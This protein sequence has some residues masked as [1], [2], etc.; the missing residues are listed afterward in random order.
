MDLHEARRLAGLPL[1]ETAKLTEASKVEVSELDAN[2]QKI[3]AKLKAIFGK[4]AADVFEGIHGIIAMFP[5]DLHNSRLDISDLK[6]LI[7]LK[8]RWIESST[9]NKYWSVGF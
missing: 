5:T 3:Y 8:I 4:D 7:A 2:K 6:K 9:D 1:K